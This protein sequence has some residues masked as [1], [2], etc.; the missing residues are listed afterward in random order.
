M[1]Q[2]LRVVDPTGGLAKP[3]GLFVETPKGGLNI[4]PIY[5]MIAYLFALFFVC[6]FAKDA[7]VTNKVRVGE[8]AQQTSS[9]PF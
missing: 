8:S 2:E 9:T 3:P 1:A 5:K 4:T 6:A 7:K